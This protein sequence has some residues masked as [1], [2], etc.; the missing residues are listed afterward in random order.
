MAEGR[1]HARTV[2]PREPGVQ[3]RR[4]DV[5]QFACG[6]AQ[7]PR[8]PGRRP[9]VSACT[10]EAP[11]TRSSLIKTIIEANSSTVGSDSRGRVNV[12]GADAVEGLTIAGCVNE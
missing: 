4:P 8:V 6:G 2:G 11:R 7:V 1:S 5:S 10:V 3:W 9:S 12:D